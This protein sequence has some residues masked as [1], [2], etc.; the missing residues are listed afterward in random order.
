[1]VHLC[2]KM[3]GI[4]RADFAND[5]L[6]VKSKLHC[7][8]LAPPPLAATLPQVIVSSISR[9]CDI[10][11]GLLLPEAILLCLAAMSSGALVSIS[12]G[13]TYSGNA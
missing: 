5:T 6:W 8:C 9:C 13:M 3:K 7:D 10:R 1:M 2:V 4:K 11:G 12:I